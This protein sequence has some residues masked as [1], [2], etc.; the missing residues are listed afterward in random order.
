MIELE[1]SDGGRARVVETDGE[2]IVL[3]SS[4]AAPP[5]ATFDA[6]VEGLGYK[7]KVRSCRREPGDE[8][9]FRIEGRLVNLARPAR[10]R[11]LQRS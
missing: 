9:R 8:Q 7:I 11:L 10:E 6:V 4:R 1:L 3:S 5:G 2:R